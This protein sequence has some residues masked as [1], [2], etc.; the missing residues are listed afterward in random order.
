MLL[1]H[2]S[3]LDACTTACPHESPRRDR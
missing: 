1:K 3:S 2:L